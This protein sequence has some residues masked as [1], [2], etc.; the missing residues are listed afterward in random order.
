MDQSELQDICRRYCEVFSEQK[1]DELEALFAADV[2]L[3]DWEVEAVGRAE[4]LQANQSIFDSVE[5]IEVEPI[6]I[7]VDGRTVIAELEIV[8]DQSDPLRVVDVIEFD[9]RGKIQT[10]RAYK[11]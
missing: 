4:V 10:L 9:G 1:L 3:R 6:A 8:I 11:G 7:Y 5:S 2:S